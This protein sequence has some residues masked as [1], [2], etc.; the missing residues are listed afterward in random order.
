[1]D[2]SLLIYEELGN[3]F[4]LVSRIGVNYFWESFFCK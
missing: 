4:V 2:M 1:M 3:Y